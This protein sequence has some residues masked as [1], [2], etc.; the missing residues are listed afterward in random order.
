M[1]FFNLKEEV[2]N[3]ELTTYGK[4]LLSKGKWKPIYYEF[5]DDDIIYDTKYSGYVEKQE[6]S[7]KRIKETVRPKIFYSFDGA[8]T[9]IKEQKKRLI[10]NPNDKT[11]FIDKRKKLSNTSLPLANSSID[12]EKIPS[13]KVKVLNGKIDYVTSS[14]NVVGLPNTSNIIH[15]NDVEYKTF[16]TK[17]EELMENE[18]NFMN[19]KYEDGT[20]IAIEDDYLL[21]DVNEDNVEILNENFD[22]EM[23]M[24]ESGS[25][26]EIEI[27]LKFFTK[28]EKVIDGIYVDNEE[29]GMEVFPILSKF[30][31]DS[32]ENQFVEFYFDVHIDREIDSKTLCKHLT[33]P[34]LEKLRAQDGYVINC[35]EDKE[36]ERADYS[37][38]SKVTQED[39]DRFEDC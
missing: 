30:P 13:W 27:P 33:E 36:L 32:V 5:Y 39:L 7:Q 14:V 26:G 34:E 24:I 9:R 37:V 2:L 6:E 22:L 25:K 3:V 28:Q 8:E 18:L 38:T 20:F 35:E 23:F 19:K 10:E 12:L 4:H 1:T 16:V 11:V 17:D 21:L 15:L 29:E 31:V